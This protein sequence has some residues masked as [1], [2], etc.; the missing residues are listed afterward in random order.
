MV[1]FYENKV[2]AMKLIE[3]LLDKGATRQ[4]IV[5]NVLRTT[6][7]G[8]RFIDNHIKLLETFKRE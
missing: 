1:N 2:K 4:Q 6:G 8:E 7:Y 5:L 3:S